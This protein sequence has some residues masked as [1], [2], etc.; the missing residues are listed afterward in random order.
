MDPIIILHHH[1]ITLKGENRQFFERKL[2][3]NVRSTLRGFQAS[4]RISGGFGRFVI[5]PGPEDNQ[6][7]LLRRLSH[8]FGIANIC[9]GVRTAQD[10][11]SFAEAAKNLLDGREFRTIRVE[12]RRVDKRFP[13]RSLEINRRLGEFLCQRYSIRADM[14]SPDETIHVEI[15]NGAAYV[16]RSR[17]PGAGGLPSG[18]SGRIVSL[19]SAGIDS[20]VAT[21]QMMRR[22]A[23]V[24]PVH[25]HSMPYTSRQSV[26]QV[27]DLVRLLTEY[28]LGSKLYT[29][30]IADLQQEIVLKAP[31]PLR[32]IL[33]RRMMVRIAEKIAWSENAEALVTG[34]AL[35]QVA[36]QTLRNIRVIDSA[37]TLPIFRP[38]AGADKEETMAV[39]RRIGTYEISKEPFDD[40]CSFLAPRR[41]ETKA[42]PDEVAAAESLLD[43]PALVAHAMEQAETETF[44]FPNLPDAGHPGLSEEPAVSGDSVDFTD[45]V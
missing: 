15:V 44:I 10:T 4:G 21:W 34:E 28:Q 43:V 26:D 39:A 37:A 32:V 20:P 45:G 16:Y 22:G 9:A 18:I 3:N 24:I 17:T 2:L 27:R 5:E 41:P 35:G 7:E 12:T 25:F 38:L 30:P 1:E 31:Q 11:D 6:E 14:K 13:I 42:K 36:S 23:T 40:C 8:V 19:L 33:Y 29:V